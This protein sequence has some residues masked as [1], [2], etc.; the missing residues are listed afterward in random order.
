[1]DASHIYST[2]EEH[3]TSLFHVNQSPALVFHNLEHTRYV[4]AK[5]NEIAAHYELTEQEMLVLYLAAWFHD[6]GYMFTSAS[7]HE[8]KSVELMKEFATKQDLSF[9]IVNDA[10]GCILATKPP[11]RPTG[12]LQEILCDADTYNLG[13]KDF[14]RTNQLVCEEFQNVAGKPLI[15]KDFDASALEMLKHHRFYTSYCKELLQDVK[16]QN[17]KKLKKQLEKKQDEIYPRV[18]EPAEITEKLGTT[19]GMQT[20]LRLTSTNHIQLSE[21]ADSKA[22]ILISVNAIIIS[23]IL[24]VLLRKLQTD[25]YLTIPTLVF[26]IFSLTTIVVSILATRP[27]LNTGTFD[28][29]DVVSKKTN[30]LFF[31]NFHRMSLPEYESAMRIMMKDA[32]Y[33]YSSIIQ[34]IYHLGVVLGRKYKLIRWAYNIFMVGIIVSVVSFALAS[35]FYSPTPTTVSTNTTGSPF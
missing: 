21:M 17:M 24:G 12:L 23:V 4:V 7:E 32:D 29:Q 1:M 16:K 15:K 6:T 18:I 5:T 25:P 3:V 28:T 9:E 26:L 19:K 27:K 33:L 30:L 20:M 8:E 11:R 2:I 14:K 10:A 34:D 35:Y 31:G 22:N 13:T